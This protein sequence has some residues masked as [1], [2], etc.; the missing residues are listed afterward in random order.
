MLEVLVPFQFIHS[1]CFDND[2][3]NMREGITD[4]RHCLVMINKLLAVEIKRY[5]RSL[6]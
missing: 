5:S 1:M 3:K 4:T 6:C 2:N